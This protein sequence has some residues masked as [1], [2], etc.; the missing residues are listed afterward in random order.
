MEYNIDTTDDDRQGQPPATSGGEREHARRAPV[1]AAELKLSNDADHFGSVIVDPGL[2]AQYHVVDTAETRFVRDLI[3]TPDRHRQWVTLPTERMGSVKARATARSWN[4]QRRIDGEPV[5]LEAV[6]I[7]RQDAKTRNL[8]TVAVMYDPDK[9][10]QSA[11]QDSPEPRESETTA[12]IPDSVP[13]ETTTPATTYDDDDRSGTDTANDESQDIE[14]G[15][16]TTYGDTIDNE[17]NPYT[18]QD[19]Q[20]PGPGQ[21]F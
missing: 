19:N 2:I 8:W 10:P 17:G 20:I 18:L 21:L 3:E 13:V 7:P 11:A 16:S 15:A 9:Q 6:A 1:K 5:K 4:R 12:D 14:P